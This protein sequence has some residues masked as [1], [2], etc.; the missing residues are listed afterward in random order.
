LEVRLRRQTDQLL[1]LTK[2]EDFDTNLE[3]AL[4]SITETAAKALLCER[5]SVWLLSE[6]HQA[7]RCTDLFQ[8]SS[9]SHSNGIELTAASYPA[10]FAY[11]AESRVLAA[12]D[13]CKN[14]STFEF[15]EGYLKPLGI[16]SMLD[17]PIRRGGKVVGVVCH[18]QVG[19][20]R[21]WTIDEQAFAGAMADF[22][23]RAYD[24]HERQIL[25]QNMIEQAHMSAIGKIAAGISHEIRTPLSVIK[26]MSEQ[27]LRRAAGKD[28]DKITTTLT[29]VLRNVDRIERIVRG[30]LNQSRSDVTTD[31][32][33]M[34]PETVDGIVEDA[35]TLCNMRL[36]LESIELRLAPIMC[37]LHVNC[38]APQLVQVLVNIINNA[39]DAIAES[40]SNE[41][42]IGINVNYQKE[43]VEIALSNSGPKIPAALA[44]K[45]LEPFFTTKSKG[46]GTGLGLS[47]S[48]S[49]IKEHGGRLFLDTNQAHTRFV[50]AIPVCATPAVLPRAS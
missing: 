12:D 16:T 44:E 26:G 2:C 8:T 19:P 29:G 40:Q 33:P 46:K 14:P 24:A 30:M 36:K 7:L 15:A 41:K 6:D 45:I 34:H 27:A 21:H 43:T 13:A 10:Y 38:R 25:R 49:I 39:C 28:F 47:I 11:L 32:E 50:I 3:S 22:A 9:H 35:L 42:W 31:A 5:A 1:T 48:Q 37:G 18:E 17:A 4:A 23:A 20:M